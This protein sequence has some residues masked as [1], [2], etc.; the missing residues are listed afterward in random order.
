MVKPI[1]SRKKSSAKPESTSWIKNMIDSSVFIR[2]HKES[3]D[4]KQ[5]IRATAIYIK[6]G[7]IIYIITP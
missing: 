3:T 6:I 2:E 1:A 4:E 7:L 5:G